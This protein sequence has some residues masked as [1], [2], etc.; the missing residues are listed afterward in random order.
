MNINNILTKNEYTKERSAK[1]L[2]KYATQKDKDLSAWSSEQPRKIRYKELGKGLPYKFAHELTPFAYYAKTYYSDNPAVRFKPCC[3]SERYDGI[4]I[5]SGDEIFVEIT[6]AIFGNE[7]AIIKEV[8]AEGRPALGAYNI[9]GV[10]KKNRAEKKRAVMDIFAG[11]ETE[12][13][14][15]KGANNPSDCINKLKELVKKSVEDKCTKSFDTSLPYGQNK[16]VLIVV[17]DNTFVR[18]GFIKRDWDDFV[19]FKRNE[20]DSMKHNFRD[21]VLFGRSDKTFIDQKFR[22]IIFNA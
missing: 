2:F 11:D 13:N 10:N 3:G 1:E 4:I 7:W 20:I 8:L 16:T 5:D 19:N 22:G 18:A 12:E 6:E 14:R 21:I 15:W 9:L 17:F